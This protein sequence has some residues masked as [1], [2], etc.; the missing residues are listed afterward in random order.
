MFLPVEKRQ[1]AERE[2]KQRVKVY[3]RL[4][5]T[6]KMTPQQADREIAM[7]TEIANDYRL[8]EPNLFL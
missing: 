4:I 5:A 7:M 2:V 1:C 3:R 8:Q 6:G